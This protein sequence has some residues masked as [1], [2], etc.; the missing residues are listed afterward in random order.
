[1]PRESFD[2][3]YSRFLLCHLT[4]PTD[5]IEEMRGLV[6]PGGLLVCEDLDFESAFT[7]PPSA[8]FARMIEMLLAFTRKRGIDHSIGRRLHRLAQEAGFVKPEISFVQPAYLSGEEKRLWEYT[9]LEAAPAVIEAN[10]TTGDEVDSLAQELR[11]LTDDE[12]CL[13]A[14]ARVT[15]VVA[16]KPA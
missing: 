16:R 3:V 8:A 9:L 13:I 2:L 10:L 7:E 15:Q 14:L 1:L 4:R 12:R 6:K 11:R 5:A